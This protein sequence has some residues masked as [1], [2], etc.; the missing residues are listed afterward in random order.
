[1]IAQVTE[2]EVP[3]GTLM[4]DVDG[5]EELQVRPQVSPGGLVTVAYLKARLDEG[6]DHL[7]IFLPLV[8]DVVP[9]LPNRYF[10]AADVQQAIA[11]RHRIAMPQETIG[12]LL[13]RA[14]GQRLLIR[15]AGRFHL[16]PTAN[17]RR[18]EL[19]RTKSTVESAQLRLG[20]SLVVF[21]ASKG[22]SYDSPKAAVEQ[23]L[24]FV[25]QQQ[26][27]LLLGTPPDEPSPRISPADSDI[28]AQFITGTV[29][30]DPSLTPV[31]TSILEGLVLYHAAFLPD[32]ADVSRRFSNLT[33][34]FDTV[35]VRQAL[36]Y[37]GIAPRLTL[38]ETIELLLAS[39]VRCVVFDKS[40]EE[41]RRI[42]RM[43][44]DKLATTA[45][46][47]SIRPSDMARHF[48]TSRYK[49]SDVQEMS[50]LLEDEIRSAGLTIAQTPR[51]VADFTY[52]EKQLAARLVDPRTRDVAEPR[53][54]HDV[55]CVAGVLTLRRGRRSNRIE[56][57]GAV[58]ATTARLVIQN[59]RLWWEE[60]EREL[61]FPPVVHIRALANLA[62]LKRPTTGSDLQVRELVTLCSAAMK[63]SAR[64]WNRF[65]AHLDQLTRTERLSDDQATAIIVSAISDRVLRDAEIDNED[66]DF[67]TA[68]LDEVV[69]RVIADYSSAAQRELVGVQE[70]AEQQLLTTQQGHAAELAR[71]QNEAADRERAASEIAQG[72]AETLR[73]HELKVDGRARRWAAFL[74]GTVYWLLTVAI[75]VAAVYFAIRLTIEQSWIGAVVAIAVLIFSAL[76]AVGVFG[77][78]RAVRVGV[79]IALHRR[80]REWLS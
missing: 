55:D 9:D 32:L 59:V 44:Q 67:D 42:L 18:S 57:C 54:E 58:F 16:A 31:L 37:D 23:L 50:A 13:R 28:V 64:T 40:V 20:E 70:Q 72:A 49:P 45:G 3:W 43:Y 80:F 33:V 62:W 2:L 12:T 34:V 79:E 52:G 8:L 68:T 71:V 60:D 46:R 6:S 53:I 26:V 56:D 35:L 21:A 17:L 15:E 75:V 65:L 29:L 47:Q 10:N 25:E 27:S 38:R 41:I 63:P 51:H 73:R 77:Q 14:A 69:D 78:V 19:A 1:M 7:G 4:N 48:L 11:E 36:G 61:G 30:S 39:G 5:S 66:G 24:Q 22:K 74:A 76:E